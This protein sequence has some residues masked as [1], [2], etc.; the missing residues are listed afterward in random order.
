MNDAV[1]MILVGMPAVLSEPFRDVEI[2]GAIARLVAKTCLGCESRLFTL[3]TLG[4]LLGG[5]LGFLSGTVRLPSHDDL[6]LIHVGGHL[7]GVT[8]VD[9]PCEQRA[10][11]RR[12]QLLRRER[13]NLESEQS[14]KASWVGRVRV[15]VGVGQSR[16]EGRGTRE[17]RERGPMARGPMLQ[18]R[19]G[20]SGRES[21]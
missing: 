19:A 5:F 6:A 13:R 8:K 12:L 16:Q 3:L 21:P 14:R 9:V 15:G 7:G 20:L 1:S 2:R 11:E 18:R 10:R 4:L 17:E